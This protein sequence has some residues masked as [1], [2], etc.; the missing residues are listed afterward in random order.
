[1]EQRANHPIQLYTFGTLRVVRDGYIVAESD[2]Q[3]RQA[4]QLLK[5]L[6][7]ERPRPVSTDRLI[8]LLWPESASQAAATTL[9][10]AINALR[11]VLEP[12][13]PNRAPSKYV[14]TQSP[15]YTFPGHPNIWLDVE[16]FEQALNR[17]EKSTVSTEK[18]LCLEAATLLYTDDYFTSDPLC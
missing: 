2:W 5:I 17:A 18:I 8:D 14:I 10:S 3:T 13:R 12:E 16:A 15:G 9:R 11:H 6:I 1:M 4:R 7:T